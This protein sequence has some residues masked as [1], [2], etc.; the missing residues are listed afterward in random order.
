M[1][2]SE[3]NS[4]KMIISKIQ[5]L[6]CAIAIAASLGCV[7]AEKKDSKDDG[8]S[9]E[10]K[11]KV[12]TTTTMITDLVKQ[13][14]G[15]KVEVSGLMGPGVD[16]HLHQ[17]TDEDVT[18]LK[19]ADAIFWHGL[20]LEAQFEKMFKD[21]EGT[22]KHVV[23]VTRSIPANKL[24]TD[25][26]AP[27]PHVWFDV[28]L[29]KHCVDEVVKG[30]SGADSENADTYKANGEKIK[31]SLTVLHEWALARTQELPKERRV[32]FTSHD[33][34]EY[35]RR[36]Y[37]FEVE[38]VIGISTEDTADNKDVTA[39]VDK[40]KNSPVKVVFTESGV[41]AKGLKQ[42]QKDAGASIGGE[43]FSDAMGQPGKMEGP[44]GAKYDV[45]TYEGM[46]RHNIN[47]IVDAL[48]K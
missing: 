41:N 37:D 11:L 8:S 9:G 30:L 12:T 44:E 7:P 33:A 20:H 24:L 22:E 32:L 15:D 14:G 47:T 16:P 23:R 13:V 38:A 42:I 25:G 26:D 35:F 34:F 43:I 19:E 31:S 36:A 2:V 39:M 17:A 1:F 4:W 45:G 18:K 28:L 40:L 27:D 3:V 21:F 29:W 10:G 6:T 48:K 46:I 5:I